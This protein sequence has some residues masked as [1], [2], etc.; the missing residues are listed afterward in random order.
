M[1]CLYAEYNA[2]VRDTTGGKSK[3]VSIG[4]YQNLAQ[5]RC[6]CQVVLV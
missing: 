5:A 2:C 3:E 6:S 4:G 1:I